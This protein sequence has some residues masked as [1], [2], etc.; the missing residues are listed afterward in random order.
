MEGIISEY[1]WTAQVKGMGKAEG[2]D[3]NIHVTAIVKSP[4]KGV[5]KA[6]D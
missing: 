5:T 4:P 1:S 6:K 2:E 3:G